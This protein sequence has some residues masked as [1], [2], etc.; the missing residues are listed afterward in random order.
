ME[1]ERQR[2]GNTQGWGIGGGDAEMESSGR[3][4]GMY[5]QMYVHRDRRVEE[6]GHRLF[7]EQRREY[8]HSDG[9][10]ERQM[11]KEM[12]RRRDRGIEELMD[13]ETEMQGKWGGEI[14]E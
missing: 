11:D 10:T 4:S 14:H 9:R 6:N 8:L 13:E 3:V 2:A 5:G 7:K 1:T 12:E